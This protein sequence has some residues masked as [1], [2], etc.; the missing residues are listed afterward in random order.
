LSLA[1]FTITGGSQP[2]VA[3]VACTK[4]NV[5]PPADGRCSITGPGTLRGADES[6]DG[7]LG[8]RLEVDG[9][10]IENVANGV[11]ADR[12]RIS[13]SVIVGASPLGYGGSMVQAARA[14]VTGSSITGSAG[15]GV[16]GARRV[17]LEDTVINGSRWD[18]AASGG[19]L[20]LIGSSVT[21]NATN[22]DM[23]FSCGPQEMARCADV[24][25]RRRVKLTAGA[26]CETSLLQERYCNGSPWDYRPGA[27]L[28]VC[29]QD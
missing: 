15:F 7:I 1:G 16:S 25:A 11:V 27:S 22:C 29:T 8:P 21:G 2:S 20:D 24:T 5:A 28:G 23:P 10:T 14:T 17:V 4:G 18:G 13:N 12:V 26:T 6:A 3:I 19:G 9:V